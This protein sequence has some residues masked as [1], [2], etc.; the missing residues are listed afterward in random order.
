MGIVGITIS[1]ILNNTFINNAAKFGGTIVLYALNQSFIENNLFFESRATLG[2]VMYIEK[3]INRIELHD[4]TF[5]NSVSFSNAG[6]FFIKNVNNSFFQNISIHSAC[7]ENNGGV[8]F[9]FETKFALFKNISAF[10]ISARTGAVFSIQN[11]HVVIYDSVFKNGESGENGGFGFFFGVTHITIEKCEI[12][13]FYSEGHGGVI[14][15]SNIDYMGIIS[16]IFA[17]IAI[18][19][20]AFGIIY[21]EGYTEYKINSTNSLG[22]FSLENVTFLQTEAVFGSNIYYSSN[23][24]LIVKD[25]ISI[26]SRGSL[27]TFES[28]QLG[29]IIFEN[30]TI[31]ETNFDHELIDKRLVENSLF[32]SI[33]A[34]V[35][36]VNVLFKLNYCNRDM[37]EIVLS[38]ISIIN[39][40][41]SDFMKGNTQNSRSQRIIYGGLS[42][43]IFQN[44]TIFNTGNESFAYCMFIK[45]QKSNFSSFNDKFTDLEIRDESVF[46][47]ENSVLS[48]NNTFIS[49]LYCNNNIFLIKS[50]IITIENCNFNVSSNKDTSKKEPLKEYLFYF[51]WDSST[52]QSIFINNTIIKISKLNGIFIFK[53]FFILIQNTDFICLSEDLSQALKINSANNSV[54]SNSN[55][56]NFFFLKGA[57]IYLEKPED[58]PYFMSVKIFQTNLLG[59]KGFLAANVYVLGSVFLNMTEC[60]FFNNSAIMANREYIDFYYLDSGKAGCMLV[61]CEYYKNCFV[62]VDNS[63]F[64]QNMA[65]NIGPT[66]ISKSMNKIQVTNSI[67]HQNFDESN[68]SATLLATPV[69]YYIISSKFERE[70]INKISEYSADIKSSIIK[71]AFSIKNNLEIASGQE[72][73]FSIML[74]DNF[75]HLLIKYSEIASHIDCAYEG[76]ISKYKDKNIFIQDGS[77]SS[78]E[79]ILYFL[80]VKI[81]FFPNTKL[82]CN[83]TLNY[84]QYLLFKSTFKGFTSNINKIVNRTLFIPLTILLRN[85]SI[86]EIYLDDQSCFICNKG[87]YSLLDPSSQ[88]VKNCKNC[89]ANAFCKGGKYISPLYGYWRYSNNSQIILKC[90]TEESCLGIDQI[91]HSLKWDNLSEIQKIQ[92]VCNKGYHGNI[93]FYCDKG[94]ARMKNNAQCEKCE[95]MIVIYIKMVFS[96][97]F[98][99]FYI[100]AQA[101]IFS[102]VESKDPNLAILVKL[103]LNHFQTISLIN[104]IDL[105]W[106][107]EFNFYFSIQDYLSFLTEDFFVIDCLIN[108]IDQDLLVQK[109]IFTILLPIILSIFMIIIWISVYFYISRLKKTIIKT[110]VYEYLIE[111]MRIT[112]L[113]LLF[114][115]YPEIIRKCFSLMNCILID[116]SNFTSVLSLSP[117]I[118]CWSGVHDEWASKVA[119][120]GLI[121]WGIVTPTIIFLIMYKNRKKIAYIVKGSSALSYKKEKSL[122]EHINV[123]LKL[124][125]ELASLI[126]EK[127]LPTK[128]DIGYISNQTTFIETIEFVLESKE[129]LEKEAEAIKE[130]PA[131]NNYNNTNSTF[132]RLIKQKEN[133]SNSKVII[134]RLEDFR[135]FLEK[136]NLTFKN[137][138]EEVFMQHLVLLE[139]TSDKKKFDFKL[140]KITIKDKNKKQTAEETMS[141]KEMVF[142][143]NLGFIYR[144]YKKEYYFWEIIMFSRKFILILIGT[145]TEIFPK[146]IKP[147]LLIIFLIGYIYL[148]TSFSPYH[149]EFLNALEILSLITAFLTACIGILLFSEKLRKISY[150]FVF[151]V[152]VINALFLF[153]WVQKLFKYGKLKEKWQDLKLTLLKLK[154]RFFFKRPGKKR[155]DNLK[156]YPEFN[157]EKNILR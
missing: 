140:R 4:L 100:S 49:R 157:I 34:K 38:Q 113:I 137:I 106:T 83:I 145:F 123:Y 56:E 28:D 16:T 19:R 5:K 119:L 114:I 42:T 151:M 45:L 68:F 116:D 17:K 44:N 94:M 77:S 138:R 93:C 92:G 147:T 31:N 102:N 128:T 99:V 50:G 10:N 41:I 131:E 69:M 59:G 1:F 98:V 62:F 154:W 30:F 120:P 112:L 142:M 71:N 104:L 134:K 40:T 53:S 130:N 76:N 78:N 115:L 125:L 152:A 2:A 18:G 111:K 21:L 139:K 149:S 117:N 73:N 39:S 63:S 22:I 24:I 84:D 96:L 95:G 65:E 51:D 23:N 97:I 26:K 15:S 12:F 52:S 3:I 48:F 72:F 32:L 89:P 143:K 122:C 108:D 13:D 47:F 9:I 105:G 132:P 36:F 6:V 20:D 153:I 33:T 148:Q 118:E 127:D 60:L 29:S 85:C 46:Y 86:G 80:N 7:S 66:I 14:M 129:T 35:T 133:N 37:F 101:K 58:E 11:S 57:C 81:F 107:V 79:G 88:V 155:E 55:F 146:Q 135:I 64:L 124:D 43:I 90:S 61:D 126:F 156:I 144:G 121:I 91:F 25:S 27:F 150:L 141:L 70:F 110:Q 54:I 67:Y 82:S 74:N 87:T 103:L 8:A 109:I 136:A 75:D